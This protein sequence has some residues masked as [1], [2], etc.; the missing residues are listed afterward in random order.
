[1][2]TFPLLACSILQRHAPVN[3]GRCGAQTALD[4]RRNFVYSHCVL[5]ATAAHGSWGLMTLSLLDDA[6][7]AAYVGCVV[8]IG[9]AGSSRRASAGEYFLASRRASWPTIGLAQFGSNISPG[10]LIGITGSAYALGISV[11]NY[12]WMASLILAVFALTFLPLLLGQRIYTMPEYFERRYDRRARIWLASLSVLLYVLLDAAGALYCAALVAQILLPH[13][14]FETVVAALAV[15]SSLYALTGGLR[16]VMR[17][18]AL[19]A[20]IMI[21]SAVLLAAFAFAR[22][23]GWHSV[24]RANPPSSLHLIMPASDPYMP[25][26]GLAFGAPLL[27]LYYWCTNQV[28]VQRVLAARSVAD[29]QRGTLLAGFLK[30]LTLLLIVAPGL[31]GRALYPHLQ[32]ADDI[33][34]RLAFGLLPPGVL[35]LF[36]AAFLGALMAA[37]SATY[38]S[39]GT[40]ISID[41]IRRARPQMDE[42]RTVRWGRIGTALCMLASALWVPQIARFPSLWQYFQAVLAYFTP[43]V[44]AVFLAGMLWPRASGRGAFASLLA[45]SA[46]GALLYLLAILG[47]SHLQFLV[48]AGWVFALSL[49]V[50]TAVSL[51]GERELAGSVPGPTGVT[52]LFGYFT[53]TPLSVRLTALGLILVTSA[54]VIKCW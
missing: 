20:L 9:F 49:A 53:A 45:G 5:R 41:F 23:G 54:I 44:A 39:A 24:L 28:M 40:M 37:L 16:P 17:T 42:R 26:T 10:A 30:L 11:Y 12:D 13:V 52:A 1:M 31:A 36:V 25:W 18:Q 15:L 4:K 50:L 43:P 6:V 46:L 2:E 7:V 35:G 21:L 32:R 14:R 3:R 19:Q 47:I 34:L 51:T 33:Y 22:V 38:N 8:V 29:G 27:A 48:A